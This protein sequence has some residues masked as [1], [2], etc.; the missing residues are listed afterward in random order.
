MKE[1]KNKSYREERTIKEQNF[2]RQKMAID[3]SFHLFE[4]G[5]QESRNEF[6]RW[7]M[8]E[9]KLLKYNLQLHITIL[10]TQ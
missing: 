8:W 10:A 3:A 5:N 7:K 2:R 4:V 9:K 6:Y 1:N